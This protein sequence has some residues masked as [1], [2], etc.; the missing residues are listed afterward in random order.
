MIGRVAFIGSL[1]ADT[2]LEVPSHLLRSL[3]VPAGDRYSTI[4]EIVFV[5]IVLTAEFS[6]SRVR[7][8]CQ[9]GTLSVVVAA[10]DIV[11]RTLRPDSRVPTTTSR[12]E[13]V[14]FK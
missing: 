12:L 2:M 1:D 11:R 7:A 4:N 9:S 8:Y 13:I 5:S 6:E 10:E 3:A 14:V